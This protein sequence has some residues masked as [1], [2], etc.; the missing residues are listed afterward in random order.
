MGKIIKTDIKRQYIKD[1]R[2]D[3][4]CRMLE[5][6]LHAATGKSHS[7]DYHESTDGSVRVEFIAKS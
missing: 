3:M 1:S 4:I 5:D 7:V 2:Y 6:L